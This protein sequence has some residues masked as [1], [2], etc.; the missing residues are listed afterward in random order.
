MTTHAVWI[1]GTP[2]SGSTITQRLVGRFENVAVVG[3]ID[4]IAA[5]NMHPHGA[6]GGGRH[7]KRRP[8]HFLPC[9]AE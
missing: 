1:V 9:G 4:R 3:E 7:Q 8:A 6:R 5:F 2:F